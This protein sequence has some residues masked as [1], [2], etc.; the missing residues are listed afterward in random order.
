[1][2]EEFL[3]SQIRTKNKKIKIPDKAGKDAKTYDEDGDQVPKKAQKYELIVRFD[4]KSII[5][6]TKTSGFQHGKSQT[7]GGGKS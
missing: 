1:M 6:P 2:S 4:K 5:A 3:Y 7:N